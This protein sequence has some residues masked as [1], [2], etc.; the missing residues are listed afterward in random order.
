[1]H[2]PYKR[3]AFAAIALLAAM[4]GGFAALHSDA[5]QAKAGAASQAPAVPVDAAAA[6]GRDITDWHEYSGRLEAVNRVEIRPLVSGTLIAVHFKD[7]SLVHKGDELFTIDPRPYAAAVDRARAQLAAARARAAYAD[8]DLARGRRLLADNAIARRDFD[9]KRNVQRVAAADLQ[10]AQ[11]ALESA[12]LDLEHTRIVAPISGR[13]SRAEITPGNVVSA[14]AGSRPLTTLVSVAR[15]YA[16]FNVDEQSFLQF[17][18]PAHGAQLPVYLGLAD[19]RGYP[20]KGRLESVDNR[21]DTASGT[22]RVRAVFD[23]ADGALVPGL[24]ARIRLGGGV[25]H[26]AVL[27]DEK[28]VGTDQD[29]RYVIVIDAAGRA[30]YRGVRI[31]SA[32]EGYRVVESGLKPGERIVVDGLQRVRPGDRLNARTVSMQGAD[33]NLAAAEPAGAGKS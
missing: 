23:N 24:Y 25:P 17:V 14:D 19:E 4:G 15:M 29:K 28:A 2:F 8:S 20:R 11:A 12:Q 26:P 21:L 32:Y 5:S 16:S 1:M 13:V 10:A 3:S 30:H 7:G 6:L 22:I 31:G 33:A 27:V 18:A 9:E